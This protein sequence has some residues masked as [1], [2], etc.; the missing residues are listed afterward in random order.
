MSS[1]GYNYVRISTCRMALPELPVLIPNCLASLIV[2]GHESVPHS[3][4]YQVALMD[5]QKRQ[6]CGGTLVN[7]WWVVTAAHCSRDS[8][9]WVGLGYHAI[10]QYDGPN[11]QVVYGNWISH[12]DFDAGTMNNDIA[13]IQLHTPVSMNSDVQAI[14]I[15]S[16]EPKK[17]LKLLVSGWGN[18]DLLGDSGGPIV[19]NCA[20]D[21][22]QAGVLLEGIMSWGR[23]CAEAAHPGVYTKISNYCDWMKH[24]SND[25]IVCV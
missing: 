25:E 18:L 15:S 12:K 3:R 6:Y 10:D 8:G 19:S 11:Q 4:P 16:N 5:E 23:G 9:P 14:S 21:S 1:S 17:G 20:A 24:F 22:H 13:L 7:K 2:G